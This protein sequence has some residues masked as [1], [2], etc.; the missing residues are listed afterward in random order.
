MLCQFP[1]TTLEISEDWFSKF[2]ALDT[3]YVIWE[4][5][6]RANLLIEETKPNTINANI[7]TEHTP[8]IRGSYI[9]AIYTTYFF[10]E[11]DVVEV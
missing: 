1:R 4:T 6:F 2:A 9:A 8:A 7:H 5:F 11:F 3:K 10:T